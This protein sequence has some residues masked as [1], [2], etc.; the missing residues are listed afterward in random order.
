M[1]KQQCKNREGRECRRREEERRVE[2]R[3]D[4]NRLGETETIE[5]LNK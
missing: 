4:M 1:R 2:V 5:G 3:E